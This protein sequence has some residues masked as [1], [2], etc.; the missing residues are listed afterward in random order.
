MSKVKNRVVMIHSK[1]F[2]Q[3]IEQA[4]A[5][6][7]PKKEVPPAT[8]AAAQ[9][10]MAPTTPVPDTSKALSTP[11]PSGGYGGTAAA[12]SKPV[13]FSPAQTPTPK[14][15]LTA[16]GNNKA[17]L[18][19]LRQASAS[20]TM[21]GPSKEAQALMSDRT[22]NILSGQSVYGGPNKL[23]A[24][25]D[26]QVGVEKM[27]TAMST[28][29][30]AVSSEPT[31]IGPAAQGGILARKDGQS[32][33]IDPKTKVFT[34]GTFDAAQSARYDKMRGVDKLKSDAATVATSK[35]SVPP[36]AGTQQTTSP[37]ATTTTALSTEQEKNYQ[38]A[39]DNM[40]NPIAQGMIKSEYNKLS[41]ADQAAFKRRAKQD[42]I[43]LPF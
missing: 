19:A 11:A 16:A 15:E 38:R 31:K 22:K 30:A 35:A 7:P 37:K 20:A 41:P 10:K 2:T 12:T 4:T 43:A 25:T 27:K 23:K 5:V 21:A 8:A 26:A 9:P 3:F 39:K 33:T 32:G 40:K 34:A 14:P 18:N 1:T 29:Q 24:G 6:V 36:P 17:D 13:A 42:S 28:P